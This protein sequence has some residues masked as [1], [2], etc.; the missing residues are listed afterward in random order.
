LGF[1]ADLRRELFWGNLKLEFFGFMG[2]VP[3]GCTEEGGQFVFHFVLWGEFVVRCTVVC[4]W[5]TRKYKTRIKKEG[6]VW[7]GQG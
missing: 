5:K 4:G 2:G 6:A 1:H 7:L 3:R